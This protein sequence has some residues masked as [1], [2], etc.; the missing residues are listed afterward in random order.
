[1]V[2]GWLFRSLGAI[3]T[4]RVV[5]WALRFC[6]GLCIVLAAT[7][8]AKTGRLFYIPAVLVIYALAFNL[9]PR[10]RDVDKK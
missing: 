8:L 7:A 1:M 6:S 10:L 3:L 5:Y 4:H 2:A 9:L